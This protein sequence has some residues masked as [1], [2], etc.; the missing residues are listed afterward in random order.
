MNSQIFSGGTVIEPEHSSDAARTAKKAYELPL[1]TLFLLDLFL[2]EATATVNQAGSIRVVMSTGSG[3]IKMLTATG[4]IGAQLHVLRSHALMTDEPS[5]S[6]ITQLHVSG[7]GKL[8]YALESGEQFVVDGDSE[9]AL[10]SPLL[11]ISDGAPNG[12]DVG[13]K[14]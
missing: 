5:V 8:V 2:D 7:D 13:A 6:M 9:P 3:V 11:H 1:G 12:L 14:A 4:I 10:L